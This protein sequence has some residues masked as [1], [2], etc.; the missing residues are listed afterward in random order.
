MLYDN[1]QLAS[2]YAQAHELTG[3][4]DFAQ[5][6]EDTL[7]F[8]QRELQHPD[9]AFYSALDAE[10]DA[11]EGLYYIWKSDELKQ[12]LGDGFDLFAEAYGASE[13][14]NWEGRHIL[15]LPRPLAETAQ[16]RAISPEQLAEQLAPLRK[17]LLELRSTRPRPLTDTKVLTSWNG[18]MIRGFADAGRLLNNAAHVETARRA[19]TC[20]LSNARTDEGRLLRT[21]GPGPAKLNAYLD[22]YAFLIDG[23]IALHQAT[24]EEQWLQEASRLMAKQLELFWDD[25]AG[26]FF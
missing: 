17:Q 20:V 25:E 15:L 10:T 22:D 9:G 11:E 23:L 7:A 18:L 4:A 24:G 1:A 19:A 14:P 21:F 8:V 26:G 16:R 13:G 12:A 3:R 5:V 2:V 6:V